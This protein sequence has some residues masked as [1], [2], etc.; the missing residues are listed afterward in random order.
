[1]KKYMLLNIGLMTVIRV[2]C[3]SVGKTKFQTQC[4]EKNH[5]NRTMILQGNNTTETRLCWTF[6]IKEEV[7]VEMHW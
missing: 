1:M 2:C 6:V 4:F 3:K 5:R 7:V